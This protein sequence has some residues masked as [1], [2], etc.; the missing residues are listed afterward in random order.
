MNAADF[1]H[2][3]AELLIAMILIR[4]AEISGPSW[5]SRPLGALFNA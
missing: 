5:L 3:F 4:F 1:V 2:F